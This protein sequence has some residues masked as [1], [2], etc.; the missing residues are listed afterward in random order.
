MTEKD[1]RTG[2]NLSYVQRDAI[3]SDLV[4]LEFHLSPTLHHKKTGVV[5][6]QAKD[7]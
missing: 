3:Y 5:L 4:L 6:Q 2:P 7:K 1:D